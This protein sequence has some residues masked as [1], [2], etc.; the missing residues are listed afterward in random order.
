MARE[1][2]LEKN[3]KKSKRS[4]TADVDGKKALK[5]LNHVEGKIQPA[6][7]QRRDLPNL[8]EKP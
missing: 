1:L 5:K 4:P 3:A 7:V 8:Q 6:D 2:K